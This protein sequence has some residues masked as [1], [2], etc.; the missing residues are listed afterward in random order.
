MIY[1]GHGASGN[2]ASMKPYVDGLEA[3]GVEAASVP[4]TGKLP[5]RAE[6]AMDVFLGLLREHPAV[7]IGGHSYS[8]RVAS[9][10]AA[11]S[12]ALPGGPVLF[13]DPPHPPGHPEE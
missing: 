2:A 11:A 13:S 3:R 4:A 10:V 7:M 5:T 8:R 6:K 1:L 12:G 9:M